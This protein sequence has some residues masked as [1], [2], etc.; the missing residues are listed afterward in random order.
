VI[1][2]EFGRRARDEI[3]AAGGELLYKE[4]PLPHTLDPQY[5]VE[6]REWMWAKWVGAAHDGA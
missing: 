4:Y 2:V 1:G 6:V 3:L 5:L